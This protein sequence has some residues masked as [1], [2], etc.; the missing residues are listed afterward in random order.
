MRVY[1][2]GRQCFESYDT[3]EEVFYEYVLKDYFHSIEKYAG[4]HYD[5][6]GRPQC[7][8][9]FGALTR[10]KD[11]IVRD[12]EVK[13]VIEIRYGCTRTVSYPPNKKGIVENVKHTEEYCYK[14]HIIKD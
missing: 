5:S 12:D 4:R 14:K 2:T 10:F 8:F 3:K 9:N 7:I 1:Y 6:Y 11:K 13:T